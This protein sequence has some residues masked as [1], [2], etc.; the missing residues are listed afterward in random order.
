MNL[1][2]HPYSKSGSMFMFKTKI[3]LKN[4]KLNNTELLKLKK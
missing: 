2:Q 4:K 3:I 1:Q